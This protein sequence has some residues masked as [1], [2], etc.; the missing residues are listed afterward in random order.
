MDEKGRMWEA[1]KL[2]SWTMN[3]YSDVWRASEE[4][5]LEEKHTRRGSKK[6]GNT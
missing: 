3:V 2:S 1:V 4:P 5:R 6:G